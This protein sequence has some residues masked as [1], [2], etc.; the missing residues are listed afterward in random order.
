MPIDWKHT[1]RSTVATAPPPRLACPIQTI[2]PSIGSQGIEQTH[3]VAPTLRHGEGRTR[4]YGFSRTCR[5]LAR[6][7]S[8][9]RSLPP[10]T[11]PPPPA[12]RPARSG[13]AGC[14][15]IGHTRLQPPASRV[16][17]IAGTGGL[18]LLSHSGGAR[19]PA[20]WRAGSGRSGR[21]H[22]K[23]AILILE[24]PIA[25]GLGFRADGDW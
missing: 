4:P 8:S 11:K 21:D 17:G 1:T 10:G 3:L 25:N 22:S 2:P 9:Y 5:S 16:G 23:S 6:R 12:V 24:Q 15:S 14:R 19:G 20:L 18:P 13:E 7:V